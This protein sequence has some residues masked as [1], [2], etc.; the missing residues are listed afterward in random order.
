MSEKETIEVV[1]ERV[2]L[3]YKNATSGYFFAKAISIAFLNY[4]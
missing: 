4:Y 2:G 1:R 3:F